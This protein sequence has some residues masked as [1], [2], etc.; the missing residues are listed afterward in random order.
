M[1]SLTDNCQHTLAHE[2][3]RKVPLFSSLP[4]EDLERL[5]ES[6]EEVCLS[7]GEVLCKEGEPGDK[8]YILKSGELEV[9][10]E[11]G[12][13][14]VLLSLRNEPGDIL[15]EMA[16]LEQMPRTATVR[17][18]RESVL[19]AIHK[20]Q[21]DHLLDISTAAA[22]AVMHT[23]LQ[24]W[25]ST[26]NVLR[27]S[28]KMAQLGTLTA[29][30]AHEL[31]NPAA[32]VKRG[33]EQLREAVAHYGEAQGRL[34]MMSLTEAQRHVLQPF[35]QLARTRATAYVEMDALSRS[36]KAYELEQWL[37]DQ[38]VPDGWELAPDLVNLALGQEELAELGETFQEGHLEAVLRRL[39]SVYNVHNL[40]TEI[41]QGATRI[42]DI[43]RALKSYSYLDQAP[44]Q[45]VDIH[46]G[47]DN[48][49]LILRHKLKGGIQ[50]KREYSPDLPKIQGYG[51]ELNQVWTN[52]IDN[53]TDALDGQGEIRLRTYTAEGSVVV[54]VEDN[55][56]GIPPH[57]LPRIFDAFFTTKPL[58]KGT[59]LGLD[60]SYNIVTFKHKGEIKV[61]SVPGR[62]TFKVVLPL[63]FGSK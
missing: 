9:L 57:V 46:E 63:D 48:T 30:V 24:R 33:A 22:K 21:F 1:N 53:A 42:S 23:V 51:S 56:P 17:A 5:C 4:E 28:E 36:D 27:Q 49:L 3:L 19:Y 61:D 6:A 26:E 12:G 13:R 39:I 60:I 15:G 35:T 37:E 29:G 32:A 14:Q 55:G 62:T 16:L 40:M 52:L 47:L 20:E 25:R 41:G 38:G 31:N 34:D 44:V 7:P 59:G 11:T 43:V 2:F 18:S 54:E 45:E 10:K 58:G 8:A 50:V